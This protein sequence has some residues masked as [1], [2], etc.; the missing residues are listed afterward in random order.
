MIICTMALLTAYIIIAS[1]QW[2]SRHQQLIDSISTLAM[3]VGNNS[4]A[5]LAFNDSE[6]AKEILSALKSEKQIIS[7]ELLFPNGQLFASYR[8][9][10]TMNHSFLY[11]VLIKTREN[12]KPL[13][14]KNYS[15]ASEKIIYGSDFIEISRKIHVGNRVV[16]SIQLRACLHKL[17]ESFIQQLLLIGGLLLITLLIAYLLAYQLQKYI[18]RPVLHLASVMK[19][20]SK[21]QDY[22]VRATAEGID[23]LGE[24]INGFN[25]MLDKIQQHDEQL[26]QANNEAQSA[27]NTA[28]QANQSKSEFLANMSHELR[29]PM[30]AILS[31]SNIGLKKLETV[32]PA[33]LGE[34]FN[35]I[36]LSGNR[37]MTLLN[38]LLDLAKL[39]AGK[40]EFNFAK[41]HLAEI[42]D[43]CAKEQEAQMHVQGITLNIAPNKCHTEAIFDQTKICQVVTNLLSNSIKF[44]PKGKNI[45][46]SIVKDTL[47]TGRRKEDH[48]LCSALR[49]IIRDEGP[50]IP[51][52]EF[53]DVFD[54][55]IQSSKTKSGAGGTGLGLAICKEI[56]DGHHGRIW[57]EN[58]IGGGAVFSFI[59]PVNCADF[60]ED[61]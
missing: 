22:S 20:V 54:K 39:E 8:T 31:F 42:I 57:V 21:S 55:F 47:P 15:N 59:I 40:M 49:L 17:Y 44:T 58:S 43:L 18:S 24:L 35:K 56:I 12:L 60:F 25:N 33:K 38:D 9:D 29:T 2:H 16:G 36:S 11:L 7:A 28:E 45:F 1:T 34:Y 53:E 32:P 30:H 3:V 27:K 10:L 13:I 51:E 4:S 19:K 46:I 23:E 14:P 6:T 48:Q 26:S 50:G 52:N 41:G 37:L 5:S 61:A